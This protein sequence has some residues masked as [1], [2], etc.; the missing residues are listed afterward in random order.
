MSQTAAAA[1][2]LLIRSARKPRCLF[3][4]IISLHFPQVF[5]FLFLQ[6][7]HTRKRKYFII[8]ILEKMQRCI[9]CMHECMSHCTVFPSVIP[10]LSNTPLSL[11]LLLL[12]FC[13]CE[14]S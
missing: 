11:L 14:G 8:Y 5:S 12:I 6:L 4:K 7:T 2:Q 13:F 3:V 1:R 10:P 9:K